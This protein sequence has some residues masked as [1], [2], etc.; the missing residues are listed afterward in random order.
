MGSVQ[1]IAVSV[2]PPSVGPRREPR[3]DPVQMIFIQVVPNRPDQLIVSHGL[4][5]GRV[6]ALELK[7]TLVSHHRRGGGRSVYR[8]AQCIA[9]EDEGWGVHYSKNVSN[10]TASLVRSERGLKLYSLLV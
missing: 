6:D 1:A 2:S 10:T 7:S 9:S 3:S 4:Q 5:G 8:Q